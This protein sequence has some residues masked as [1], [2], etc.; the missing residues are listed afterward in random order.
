MSIETSC[1]DGRLVAKSINGAPLNDLDR[2]ALK[3]RAKEPGIT[4]DDV[5]GVFNGGYVVRLDLECTHCDNARIVKV[6]E[7]WQ[8]HYCGRVARGK[9]ENESNYSL[10]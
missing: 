1:I 3:K 4:V 9:K 8:C 6:R 7:R 5:L 2:A 10:A